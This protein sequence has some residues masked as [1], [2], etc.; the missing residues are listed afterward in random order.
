M[1]FVSQLL[2][3]KPTGKG[4]KPYQPPGIWESIGFQGSTTL[5]YSQ[6]KGDA[7]YRRT[8]YHFWKRTAPPPSMMT[9][10]AP[11]REA[12]VVRRSRT[13]TPLQ[14]LALM[15]DVQYIEAARNLAQRVMLADAATLTRRASEGVPPAADRLALVF[16]LSAARQPTADEQAVLLEVFQAHLTK[17]QADRAAAEKLITLGESKRNES[18]DISELAAF[19]MTCNLILNLDEVV[20]KE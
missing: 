11:S 8:L 10:D 16:R 20:T 1:L 6:D 17:Y 7:L 14:A 18:L 13:N 15:N 2:V 9:F 5:N 4:V 19:T 12:C 3:E